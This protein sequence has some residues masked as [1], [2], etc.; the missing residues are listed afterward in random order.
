MPNESLK[1]KLQKNTSKFLKELAI[2]VK[3]ASSLIEI[4]YGRSTWPKSSLHFFFFIIQFPN[5]G[6]EMGMYLWKMIYDNI[7]NK[8]PLLTGSE[9]CFDGKTAL[10]IAAKHGNL[11]ICQYIMEHVKD[12]KPESNG[13]T[14][15]HAAI[16]SR[17]HNLCQ[18]FIEKGVDLNM[19][20]DIEISPLDYAKGIGS[21]DTVELIKAS[22]NKA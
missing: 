22:L 14:V 7:D 20:N 15:F 11:E 6:M 12:L 21:D 2:F 1:K 16:F 4:E 13:D 17:S 5:D 18:Y 9:G 8:N 19:T 10:Y 3:S